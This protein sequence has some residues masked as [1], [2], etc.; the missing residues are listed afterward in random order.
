MLANDFLH[1]S[2]IKNIRK[3]QSIFY[4]GINS[5]FPLLSQ[6]RVCVIRTVNVQTLPIM[7]IIPNSNPGSKSQE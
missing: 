1:D 2:S 7:W 3:P 5:G 4:N 6:P